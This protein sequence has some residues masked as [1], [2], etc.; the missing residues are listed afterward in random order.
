MYGQALDVAVEVVPEEMVDRVSSYC[1]RPSNLS[2]TNTQGGVK[3][4]FQVDPTKH[5]KIANSHLYHIHMQYTK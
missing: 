2:P 3:Q 1:S 4:M 5:F